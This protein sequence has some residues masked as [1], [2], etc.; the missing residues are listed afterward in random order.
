MVAIQSWNQHW[1]TISYFPD[2]NLILFLDDRDFSQDA[3]ENKNMD[4]PH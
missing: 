2:E 4:F 1:L 3:Y